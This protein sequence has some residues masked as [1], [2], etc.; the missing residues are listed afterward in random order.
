[1]PEILDTAT[2]LITKFASPK[3]IAKNFASLYRHCA[4]KNTGVVF[5][6]RYV[7]AVREAT[8]VAASCRELIAA[9]INPRDILILLANKRVQ[10]RGIV[11]QLEVAGVPFGVPSD[12]FPD[13]DSGRLLRAILRVVC[14]KRRLRRAP[15]DSWPTNWDGYSHL[16]SNL[17]SCC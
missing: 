16:P 7:S 10:Q 8:A 14:K 4:P 1:M 6:W 9:G 11:D 15:N 13:A 2:A 3:R 5:R 17:R 12:D